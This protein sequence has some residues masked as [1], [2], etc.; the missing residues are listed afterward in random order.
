M[1]KSTALS[2]K[3]P[4]IS[5]ADN[6][7]DQTPSLHRCSNHLARQTF[8]TSCLGVYRCDPALLSVYAE[9]LLGRLSSLSADAVS[10]VT[11]EAAS[12]PGRLAWVSPTHSCRRGL[13]GQGRCGSTHREI[14]EKSDVASLR[15]LSRELKG[16]D[17]NPDLGRALARRVAPRVFVEDLGRIEIRIGDKT[18]PGTRYDARLLRCLPSFWRN[19]T[20]RRLATGCWMPSG[21]TRIRR[22]LPILCTRRCTSSGESSSRPTPMICRLATCTTILTSFGSTLSLSIAGA[23]S[24]VV[25]SSRSAHERLE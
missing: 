20:C 7:P 10:V 17:R 3:L 18:L 12:R 13:G 4:L 9:V 19:R 21:Q 25:S 22:R 6:G 5:R 16:E 23:R 8:R 14:G 15:I 1:D 2:S 11:S 24:C